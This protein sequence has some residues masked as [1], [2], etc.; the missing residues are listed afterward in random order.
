M[1]P[2]PP[3]LTLRNIR[4]GFGGH[5]LFTGVDCS[6]GRGDRVC[7]VGRNGSGKSTLLK[8]MAGLVAAEEGEIFTQPGVRIAYLPQ[9]PD[10]SGFE[11]LHD[12][13]ASGLGPEQLHELH[14]VDIFLDDVQLS[15]L[16]N[17]ATLSGGEKRR[18][19]LARML[20][21][22]PDILLL[23]EPTNHLDMPTI[24]WLEEKLLAY[25]GGFV[26]ISHD[27]A[28]LSRLTKVTFW[29]DRGVVR[30][31]E[32]GFAAFEA[33]SD[34]ILEREATE[35]AKFDKLIAQETV[36]SRQGI[37]ARRTRNMGRLR[38][39]HDMRSERA[40]MIAR[41][42]SVKMESD[43][44][45]T[46][47]K[48]VVEAENV[49][50]TFEG[51]TVIRPFSTRILRGDKLGVI[52]PNGAGKSTL[53]KM[54]TGQLSPDEGTIRLGTNLEMVYLD[55]SRTALDPTKTIWE[56]LADTGGDSINVRGRVR[57]VVS[58]MRD[59]LFDDRQTRS[60]VGS[61]SGGERN[62]LLLAKAL[63]KP[64]NFLIL[65]EP[66]ND[67]DMETLDLL[68]ELLADYEGTLVLVSH[69][70]DF[71]DRV[72][73]S[74]IAFEGEGVVREYPGGY[75]DY[76]RQRPTAAAVASKSSAD[77]AATAKTSERSSEKPKSKGKLSYKQQRA[78][79]ELPKTMAALEKEIAALEKTLAD[80]D[81]F[82]KDS[83]KFQATSVLLDEKRAA[84]AQAEEDWLEIEMLR[85]ELEG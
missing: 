79:E 58:Y 26:V 53:L 56:T 19:A 22:E 42:G 14:M 41:V 40:S 47:G 6:V 11:T 71:L 31:L 44:G 43:A 54:L 51:R 62:R 30:R 85:E 13:V 45:P 21:S 12:Y 81:F 74:T 29:L 2:S 39:L 9:E 63:A 78:S 18:A 68:Q 10:L 20:V 61:L 33:W 7:L 82:R 69:D 15:P 16:A 49:S 77:K 59:F 65:D 17:P 34:D 1:P 70:R 35:T 46:S 84:L 52:G 28:F 64:S 38:R 5:P 4:L 66:T 50:K 48:L 23:D 75:A 25:R 76:E 83:R 24:Q 57:H 72:V 67:L 36:W 3:L 27:R 37:K 32:D 8:V 73:T 60:P 55:Q 80:P